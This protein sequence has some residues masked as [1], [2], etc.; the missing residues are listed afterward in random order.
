MKKIIMILEREVK[1]KEML[2]KWKSMK[3]S[4]PK[5]NFENVAERE[6]KRKEEEEKKRQQ[7]R[8]LREEKVNYGDMIR[9][10]RSPEISDNHKKER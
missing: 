4:L 5:C 8:I 9:E 7:V 3:S 1:K 10:K 2:E 6:Q